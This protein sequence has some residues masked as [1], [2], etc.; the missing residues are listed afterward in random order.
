MPPFKSISAAIRSKIS[1]FCRLPCKIRGERGLFIVRDR[2]SGQKFPFEEIKKGGGI[3]ENG[4]DK[5]ERYNL[6][7]YAQKAEG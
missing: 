6:G 7:A 5:R 1:P 3:C 2:V 4:A